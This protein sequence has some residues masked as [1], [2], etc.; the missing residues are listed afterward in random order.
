MKRTGTVPAYEKEYFRKDGSR[1]PVLV[2][3][4]GLENG[5]YSVAFVLDVTE[6]KMAEEAL[7]GSEERF[8]TLTQFS[9]EVYWETDAQHRFIRLASE[10]LKDAPPLQS[11]IGKTRW[12]LPYLEPDAEGWRIHREA[13][14][15]HL[16]FRDF[17]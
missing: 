2:G 5:S 15:A 11:E 14:E 13:L 8:R 16:P 6:R 4:A 1:V 3:A 7:R 9:F 10:R 12:E 17:E